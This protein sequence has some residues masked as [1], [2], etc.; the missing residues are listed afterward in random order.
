MT[1]VR[2][3]AA[4]ALLA[5]AVTA[6]AS[7][8]AH[9]VPRPTYTGGDG[10][11]RLVASPFVVVHYTRTGP[12]HPR[13]MRDDDH[14]GVPNYVEK[15]AAAANK[16]WLWYAHN[17]FHA[18][19]P[20]TGGPDSRVDIYVKALPPG[21][22]GETFPTARAQGGAFM[23]VDNQLD[24]A[25]V[26]THGSLQQTVAHELFHLF[27]N[28][29]VPSGRIPAWAA[30]GSALAMQTYV[31]PQIVDRATFQY[32][33]AWLSQ[34]WRSVF[35]QGRGCIHCYGGALFWRF[36]FGLG[37]NVVSQ[38]FGR[39]YGYTKVHR[40]IGLG[41]QPLDEVLH[42]YAHG[43]LY[44]AYTRF[45]YDI[46]RAGYEPAPLYSIAATPTPVRTRPCVVRGL[47]T[48]YIPIRVPETAEGIGVGVAAVAGPNPAAT[49]VVGG[50]KG[51]RVARV[52]RDRGHVQL[53]VTSFRNARE[54]THVMLI[55]TSGRAVGTAYQVATQSL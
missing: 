14:D 44:D 41:L 9:L 38:Y 15:L 54:R 30:E 55:V 19:L 7:A 33:D 21:V 2:R 22:Y 39:L 40:A 34:P 46:Y 51:R 3:A 10:P 16:A 5:L 12:D 43:S 24:M 32:L 25:H 47:S 17:G 49:L 18:P 31:Y 36:L 8:G 50:P 6:S 11:E 42:R 45:S 29:Y 20:D 23:V 1:V 27:Q 26:A 52:M 53:F 13:F 4:A 48:H 35:D 37:G 28:A